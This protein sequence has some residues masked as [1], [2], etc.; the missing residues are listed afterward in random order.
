MQH[1]EPDLSGNTDFEQTWQLVWTECLAWTYLMQ[2]VRLSGIVG[3]LFAKAD[4]STWLIIWGLLSWM[5]FFLHI[6]N[7]TS[8]YLLHHDFMSQNCYTVQ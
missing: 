6:L 4:F 3:T 7:N 2:N 1:D 5:I 8:W